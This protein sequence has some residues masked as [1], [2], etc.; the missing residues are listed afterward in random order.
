[1]VKAEDCEVVVQFASEQRGDARKIPSASLR[2]GSSLRL[3]NGC[4]QDDAL[5]RCSSESKL[6]RFG[7]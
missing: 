6:H 4:A 1:M 2:A 3:N 7:L 5:Q